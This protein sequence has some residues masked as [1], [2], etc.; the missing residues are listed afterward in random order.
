MF[1]NPFA[2]YPIPFELLPEATHWFDEDGEIRCA[3][4]Y[5]HSILWSRTVVLNESDRVPR[6]EDFL[7]REEAEA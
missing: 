5:E 4:V 2:R 6:I 1:H 7:A 3:A